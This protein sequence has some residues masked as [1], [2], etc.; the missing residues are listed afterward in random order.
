[1]TEKEH[2]CVKKGRFGGSKMTQHLIILRKSEK[3]TASYRKSE[4][5]V[6]FE[7]LRSESPQMLKSQFTYVRTFHRMYLSRLWTSTN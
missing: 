6:F 5:D 1:M 3:D 7:K 2:I 4:I